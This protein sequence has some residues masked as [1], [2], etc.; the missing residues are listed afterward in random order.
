MQKLTITIILICSVLALQAQPNKSYLK[1]KTRKLDKRI[2]QSDVYRQLEKLQ[3]LPDSARSFAIETTIASLEEQLKT[4]DLDE[5]RP[6]NEKLRPILKQ[7]KDQRAKQSLARLGDTPNQPWVERGPNNVGGR[8]RALIFDLS[9]PTGK[10]AFAGGVDGGIWFNPD[11]TNANSAWQLKT[12]IAENIAISCLAQDP[13]NPAIL[14]AGTGE[15][16]EN[17]DAT[18]GMGIFI[19]TN[20]GN[21]WK[22]LPQ[23][24]TNNGFNQLTS[25]FHYVPKIIVTKQQVNGKSRV[26]IA[27]GNGIANDPYGSA[28]LYSDDYCQT[29]Y[30]CSPQSQMMGKIW[31]DI[32]VAW[33]G[34]GANLYQVLYAS[35]GK[36][37]VPGGIYRSL[38]NGA[39][40]TDISFGGN[41]KERIELATSN[42]NPNYLYAIA[43]SNSIIKINYYNQI[44]QKYEEHQNDLIFF[45]RTTNAGVNFNFILDSNL[46]IDIPLFNSSNCYKYV[47]TTIGFV[48]P[49]LQSPTFTDGQAWYD[50]ILQVHPTNPNIILAGGKDLLRSENGGKSFN[51]IAI[52]N[53]STGTCSNKSIVHADHHAIMFHPTIT[54][55]VVFGNDGGVYYCADIATSTTNPNFYNPVIQARNNNYNVT[56][57][58]HAAINPTAGSNQLLGGTQDNGSQLFT[59]TGLNSTRKVS[60][61]DGMF[62]YIDNTNSARQFTT[63]QNLTQI[64]VTQNNWTGGIYQYIL[65]PPKKTTS[66]VPV[67]A[68][69]AVNKI[70]FST[71]NSDWSNSGQTSN[72]L[73]IL[74]NIFTSPGNNFTA[75]EQSSQYGYNFTAIA[76]SKYSTVLGNSVLIAAFSNSKI[77]KINHAEKDEFDFDQNGT[78]YDYVTDLDPNNQLPAGNISCIEIGGSESELLVTFSNYSRTD[79]NVWYT[80]NAGVTWQRKDNFYS[81]QIIFPFANGVLPDMPVRWAIFNP[82][83]R[84]EVYLATEMGVWVTPNITTTGVAQWFPTNTFPFVRTDNMAYR[85][86]DWNVVAAT[87]GR[88]LWT[89]VFK[90]INGN[91]EEIEEE[92]IELFNLSTN[93][94]LLI[95]PNPANDKIKIIIKN[96]ES[97]LCKIEI[98]SA[99]GNIVY[100]KEINIF[101]DNIDVSE[102]ENGL[103]FINVSNSKQ[104]LAS[105]LLIKK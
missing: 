98:S 103:F 100:L 88:G 9:D 15:V 64:Y 42:A 39:N 93:P 14:Y 28:L 71:F 105:K 96:F 37:G 54:S 34:S 7:L 12:T 31:T 53:A 101:E 18:R 50:L 36:V 62:S 57:F 87:H 6:T 5:G 58:W 79:G 11:I 16:F 65:T 47:G 69:D 8:T 33:T 70:L 26:I 78:G 30:V 94:E 73:Y 104:R 74:K 48:I 4:M 85:I 3:E 43:S 97:E 84:N 10:R 52:R 55:S 102:F 99:T 44:T 25:G 19:S 95:Y 89:S 51:T 23:T 38:D 27:T 60:G 2:S 68:F 49:E 41:N 91:R 22:I 59:S 46:N 83:N 75:L 81:Q 80:N 76:V 1:F 86:S 61:G 20:T 66:F 82:K 24:I 13:N 32:E 40:W 67:V 45:A 21:T 63:M 72:G 56:Q 35:Y 77:Y 90:D 17:V 92:N 29:W